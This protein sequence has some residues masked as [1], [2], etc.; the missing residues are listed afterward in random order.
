LQKRPTIEAKETYYRGLARS[1][2]Y[3][4][5]CLCVYVCMYV[6]AYACMCVCM[7][8]VAYACMCV[9]KWYYVN[10]ERGNAADKLNGRNIN[11]SFT[12]D[13]NVPVEVMV[14]IF[15]FN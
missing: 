6:V 3:V 7:Y 9:C 14:F 10:V 2:V 5:S 13:S 11:V 1:C 8:V 4:C 12:N 15:L